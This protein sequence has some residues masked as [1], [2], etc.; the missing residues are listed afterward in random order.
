MHQVGVVLYRNLKLLVDNYGPFML[1]HFG[2]IP[3]FIVCSAQAAEDIMR[4]HDVVFVERPGLTVD[5][6]FFFDWSDL[7]FCPYNKY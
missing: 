7:A 2:T 4:D 1:L 6:V 3:T 5:Y